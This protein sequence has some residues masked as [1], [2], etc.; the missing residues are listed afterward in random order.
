LLESIMNEITA[1]KTSATSYKYPHRPVLIIAQVW[2]Y[3]RQAVLKS[4][5]GHL[6]C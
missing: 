1:D 3:L 6:I 2:R 4:G 5:T